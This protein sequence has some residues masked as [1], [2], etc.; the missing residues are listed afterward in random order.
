MMRSTSRGEVRA[1]TC[2]LVLMSTATGMMAVTPTATRMTTPMPPSVRAN[3][4]S[5]LRGRPRAAARAVPS[6][7][8]I[9]GA[10]SMAPMMVVAESAATPA[11]AMT[12]AVTRRMKNDEYWRR[13]SSTRTNPDRSAAMT[14]SGSSVPPSRILA[15][16]VMACPT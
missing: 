8:D 11:V 9:R 1:S 16:H 3:V 15:N 12:A 10:T 14:T 2:V 5:V 4:W 7:G 6:M 13:G